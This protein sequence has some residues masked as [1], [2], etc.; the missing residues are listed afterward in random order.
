MFSLFARTVRGLLK[1]AYT[2]FRKLLLKVALSENRAIASWSARSSS[3]ILKARLVPRGLKL[4]SAFLLVSIPVVTGVT[5]HPGSV[6]PSSWEAN[7]PV[8]K[9]AKVSSSTPVRLPIEVYP[10][11]GTSTH[12]ESIT[13]TVSN[14]AQVDSIYVQA[15]QPF[16]HINGVEGPADMSIIQGAAEMRVNGG[17]WAAIHNGNVNCASLDSKFGCVGGVHATIRFTFPAGVSGTIR[18]GENTIEFKFNGTDGIRSGYRILGIGMMTAADPSVQ[19]FDPFIHGVHD[20]SAFVRDLGDGGPPAGYDNVSDINAGATLWNSEGILHELNGENIQASC[21]S[22]HAKDGRDLKYF[23]YSNRSII[24]RSRGHG[25]TDRQ[26]R[27]IAAYIR[28]VD[29]R[30]ENGETYAPP[31]TPWNP[32]YQPGLGFGPSKD[33]SPDEVNQVY[34]A[35]GAGL[36]WVLDFERKGSGARDM[37]AHIFPKNGDPA[38]GVDYLADGSLNWL[39]VKFEDQE[40]NPINLREMPITNQFPDWNNWLPD[41]HPMDAAP[42]MF[43]GGEAETHY[44]NDLPAAF[45]SGDLGDI[46]REIKRF[47]IKFRND[48]LH[49]IGQW[50]CDTEKEWYLA[51]TSA[52][53]WKLMKVWELNHKYHLEDKADD[54]NGNGQNRPYNEPLGWIG[55][56]RVAFDVAP[57]ISAPSSPHDSPWAYANASQDF[58]FSHIW[59]Q[60]QAVLNPGVSEAA[61]GQT[62]VDWGYQEMYLNG[63][64]GYYGVGM[65]LRQFASEIKNLQL[66]SNGWGVDGRGNDGTPGNMDSGKFNWGWTPEQSLS[67]RLF[68]YAEGRMGYDVQSKN[69]SDREKTILL[70]AYLR[71]F[72]DYTKD[73]PLDEYPRDDQDDN[74]TYDGP[75]YSPEFGGLFNKPEYQN[76]LYRGIYDVS[77]NLPGVSP[78]LLDSIAQWGDDMWPDDREDYPG[79][80]TYAWPN[81]PRWS[82][83]VTNHDQTISLV[84]NI[85]LEEGWNLVSSRITP[86]STDVV[87]LL[88]PI[89]DGLVVMKNG[90]GDV[91]APGEKNEIG[92]WDTSEAYML[93][94]TSG[95]T[96]SIEG[97]S[98]PSRKVILEPGWNFVPYLSDT[99][100]PVEQVFESVGEALVIVKNNKGQ[101]YI[102]GYGVNE[103]GDL[104]P[105]NGYKVFVSETATL[106]FP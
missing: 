55:R 64:S 77:K 81:Q 3:H 86:R 96:L 41:I 36:E 74:E 26:G 92:T 23:R 18:N 94:V 99:D 46:E 59:Y 44:E 100:R 39:H 85:R 97:N 68:K 16:Y 6:V 93:Y 9:P 50:C 54:Y 71:A 82:E 103:L 89:L 84:Q 12:V 29:L 10:S 104:S 51:T 24:S 101:T 31:G 52:Y 43:N 83:I 22:C 38:N 8:A 106:T 13:L 1:T 47:G 62:P 32:P 87:R 17:Q 56:D 33:Q 27:Q 95:G 79:Q 58:Y 40:S 98:L 63:A 90:G 73:I 21:G 37:L 14:A 4:R 61:S 28:S 20:A 102:P 11:D 69:L 60:I 49:G 25:L 7:S 57:H 35:A 42:G 30:K 75:Q 65:G 53:Q 91:F 67:D 88:D 19:S 78:A 76:I 15:H 70:E 45:E 66:A 34:W 72:W 2:N 105:G 48:Y 5:L 80:P